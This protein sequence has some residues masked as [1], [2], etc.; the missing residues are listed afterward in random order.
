MTPLDICLLLSTVIGAQQDNQLNDQQLTALYTFIE[1]LNCPNQQIGNYGLFS[2][3]S[4][5]DN[6]S[7]NDSDS[8][9]DSEGRSSQDDPKADDNKD[10]T[11]DNEDEDEDESNNDLPSCDDDNRPKPGSCHDSKDVD[12]CEEFGKCD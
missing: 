7:D 8:D 4:S 1:T 2:D 9:Q 11:R 3:S 5:I 6:D 12:E 10:E